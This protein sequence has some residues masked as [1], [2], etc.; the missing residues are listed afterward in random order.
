MRTA[1]IVLCGGRSN[2]M[3]RPKA[4]LPF[5]NEL[6]LPRVVRILAD[7]VCPVVVVAAPGQDLP[8][9]PA[10]VEVLRDREEGRG[11]LE[12]LASGLA[13]LHDRADAAFLSACDSPFVRPEFIRRM[14]ALI[15]DNWIC[16]PRIGGI[17]EPLAAVYRLEV[18]ETVQRLLRENRFGPMGLFESA[19]T[20][21]VNPSE[22]SDVDPTLESLR[23]LNTREEY[24]AA[25]R[26]LTAIAE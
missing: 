17:H 11:P 15:G 4:W 10:A 22:L 23:N 16:A 1:G 6:M 25:L 12:G 9:L 14:I 7:V 5:G 21:S 3:G 8:P 2:R 19:P 20:R 24:E 13:S 18:R 26:D